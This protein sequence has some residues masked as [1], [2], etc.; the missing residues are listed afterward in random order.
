M[1]LLDQTPQDYY[2]GNDFGNYQFISLADIINQFMLIYVGEDKIIP[3]AKR[4][5]V[6]FHAQRALA[7]LSFDTLKSHKAQEFTIPSTLQLPLPQ[8]YV[9]YTKISWVD[10]AGIKHLMYPASKTSNPSSNPHQ[11]SNG[12][13]KLEEKGTTTS[14][15]NSITMVDKF[16]NILVGMTVSGL[17]IPGGEGVVE[18]VSHSTGSTPQTTITVINQAGASLNS[19]YTGRIQLQFKNPD[20]SLILPDNATHVIDNLDWTGSDYKI[21]ADA[22]ADIASLE[23]GMLVYHQR[24]PIGTKINSITNTTIHVDNVATLSVSA[25]SAQVVFVDPNKDTD[26]WSKYK[27]ATASKTDNDDYRDDT[28]WPIHGER[29][30]INPQYAQVNGSFYIDDV[31]GKIHF[32]SNVNGEVVIL[33]YVSD[34]LGSDEEMVVH[35]FAEEAMYKWMIYAIASG[36]IAT[37]E[38]LVQRLKKERFAA[39]RNAKLRLSNLNIEEL[40]QVL[41]GKSK[42]IKH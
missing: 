31:V 19:T 1:A 34:S 6:A 12:D 21:E 10:S 38:Y 3:K 16:E 4:L 14:G 7:E 33:D 2:D 39:V 40:T 22:V 18:S 23:V 27:S 30:G 28:Y 13:F 35:K 29:Y 11:D 36:K 5:D 24:F 20:G 37:P 25:N 15:S 9:S 8:D 41:R 17:Y 32:S 26:T 42:W